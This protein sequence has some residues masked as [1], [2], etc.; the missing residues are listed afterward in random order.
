M[1]VGK[2]ASTVLRIAD[3][4]DVAVL[5]LGAHRQRALGTKIPGHLGDRHADLQLADAPGAMEELSGDA[6][7]NHHETA[8]QARECS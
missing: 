6:Q 8:L 1:A 7:A 5:V 3:E 2:P 4:Q